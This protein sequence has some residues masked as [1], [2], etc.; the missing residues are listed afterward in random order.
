ME[1]RLLYLVFIGLFLNLTFVSAQTTSHYKTNVIKD[2][3]GYW[4]IQPLALS[5]RIFDTG[6]SLK[7]LCSK[8]GN[9]FG[10]LKNELVADLVSIGGHKYKFTFYN[11]Y[12]DQPKTE[13]V[14]LVH[15]NQML[16]L[17]GEVFISRN[18]ETNS[19]V[20]SNT[21]SQGINRDTYH[22]NNQ[23]RLFAACSHSKPS[24]QWL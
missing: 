14:L 20:A 3:E 6:K 19:N 9:N 18:H 17:K 21:Y 16:T 10:Y 13:M 12:G 23:R 22:E 8:S 7:A 5:I 4:E 2:I 11:K 15:N 1:K 24:A